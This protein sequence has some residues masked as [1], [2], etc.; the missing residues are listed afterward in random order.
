MTRGVRRCVEFILEL[1]GRVEQYE[2]RLRRV[3]GA[4]AAGFAHEFHTTVDGSTEDAR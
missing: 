2:D 3:G 1:A 4:G